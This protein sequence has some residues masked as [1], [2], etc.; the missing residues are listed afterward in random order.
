MLV[1]A[2]GRQLYHQP[3][4]RPGAGGEQGPWRA[5]VQQIEMLARAFAQDANGI[6]HHVHADQPRQ[7]GRRLDVPAEIRRH[8]AQ[9]G[10]GS[11]AR[12]ARGD[13]HVMA[14]RQQGVGKMATDETTGAGKQYDQEPSFLDAVR[15]SICFRSGERAIKGTGGYF[16]H[17]TACRYDSGLSGEFMSNRLMK[18]SMKTWRKAWKDGLM[19]GAI[20]SL[21]ST[22]ALSVAGQKEIGSVLGP[23]NVIS[24]WLWGDRTA[25]HHEASLRYTATGY[26]IHHASATLWAVVYEKLSEKPEQSLPDRI[27]GGLGVA[28]MACFTDYKLTPYRLQPGYEKHLSRPALALVYGSFGLALAARGALARTNERH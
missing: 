12:L 8:L 14:V 26:A 4:A 23:I 7:P 13:D 28:A 25:H 21:T 10:P 9:A 2:Q 18:D 11:M 17:P 22:V 20:G 27:A 19:S 24:R 16:F 1:G 5:F 6:D 15:E 3:H